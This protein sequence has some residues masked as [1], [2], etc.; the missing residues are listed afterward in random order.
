MASPYPH[1]ESTFP[2]SRTILA[3]DAGRRTGQARPRPRSGSPAAILLA[4]TILT[5][6]GSPSLLDGARRRGRSAS[7]QAGD[8]RRQEL[9]QHRR[10]FGVLGTAGGMAEIAVELE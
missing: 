2:Q 7:V 1:R 5:W 6:R 9:A 10:P 3:E 4:C 8:Q